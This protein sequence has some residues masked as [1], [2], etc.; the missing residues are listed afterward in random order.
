[1][2]TP[3]SYRRLLASVSVLVILSAAGCKS[4]SDPSDIPEATFPEGADTVYTRNAAMDA[5]AYDG[6]RALTIIDSAR[7]VGNLTDFWADLLRMKV[8]SQSLEG[9]RLDSTL[10]IGHR[11]LEDETLT[12]KAENRLDVLDMLVNAARQVPDDEQLVL[13]TQ[14]KAAVCRELG[15]ETEALRTEAERAVVLARLGHTD[16]G[17]KL[18]EGII[19]QL[20][21]VRRFNEMDTWIVAIRRKISILESLPGSSGQIVTLSLRILSRLE[22][23]ARNPDIY[24][25]GSFRE[26]DDEDKPAYIEFYQSKCYAKLAGAYADTDPAEARR[27]L[28]K[29]EQTDNGRSYT[30]RVMIAPILCRLGEFEKMEAIYQEMDARTEPSDTLTDAYV[31]MLHDRAVAAE[32]QGRTDDALSLWKRYDALKGILADRTLTGKTHLYAVRYQIEEQQRALEQEQAKRRRLVAFNVFLGILIVLIVL[33]LVFTHVRRSKKTPEPVRQGGDH[34]AGTIPAPAKQPADMNDEELF[35]YLSEVIRREQLYLNPL[36]DRQTLIKRFGVSAHRI[37][38][39]FSKGSTYQSLPGY[40]RSLRLEHACTLLISHPEMSVKAIGEASG[41]S[42]K[43]TFRSDF[44]T[45][46]GVTPSGYRQANLPQ[47]G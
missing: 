47:I 5:M 14:Q 45:F 18:L 36:L 42:N 41:F 1:M 46:Y 27:Y 16:E 15:D 7:L 40:I 12:L 31:T 39:A 26:P 24:R 28:A 30:G 2:K 44:K 25:D 17:L 32:T 13:W 43:S 23:Y 20:D 37:G 3:H 9:Q 38:A 33:Y 35:Q 6:E 8:Y 21:G 19:D 22:D 29:Y 4:I 11:L 34:P 10:A